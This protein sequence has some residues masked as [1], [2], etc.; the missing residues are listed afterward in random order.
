MV[1]WLE[2]TIPLVSREAQNREAQRYPGWRSLKL[3][4]ALRLL[5]DLNT[6]D[7]L[8]IQHHPLCNCSSPRRCSWETMKCAY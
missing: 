5:F 6:A 3:Q 2:T 8:Y 7:D 4:D 1:N